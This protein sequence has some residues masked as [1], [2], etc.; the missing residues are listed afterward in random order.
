MIYNINKI[1]NEIDND[2][3]NIKPQLTTLTTITDDNIYD[4]YNKKT[5]EIKNKK[6]NE[7]KKTLNDYIIQ[8]QHK[9]ND[10]KTNN[11]KIIKD[12]EN[13]IYKLK[14]LKKILN[15][16]L[17]ERYN[18]YLKSS[19][20]IKKYDEYNKNYEIEMN[21]KRDVI[22]REHTNKINEELDKSFKKINI[23][24]RN[25]ELKIKELDKE[26]KNM[27]DSIENNKNLIEENNNLIKQNKDLNESIEKNISDIEKLNDLELKNEELLKKIDK[28]N[29]ILK[30][31]K[32]N[33]KLKKNISD[34]IKNKEKDIKIKE[35]YILDLKEEEK[36]LNKKINN[37]NILNNSLNEKLNNLNDLI[38]TK[39]TEYNVI[40]EDIVIKNN[41]LLNIIDKINITSDD[42]N[43]ITKEYNL[44]KNESLNLKIIA[45]KNK[46][47][48]KK[49]VLNK[50]DNDNDDDIFNQPTIIKN[51]KTYNN[52]PIEKA[53]FENIANIKR[54]PKL[55]LKNITKK[56]EIEE[57]NN[58]KSK[59]E[60]EDEI[61]NDLNIKS[62]N[63]IFNNY[64]TD[65]ITDSATIDNREILDFLYEFNEDNDSVILDKYKKLA[66]NNEDIPVKL[67][68]KRIDI[69]RKSFNGFSFNKVNE[70]ML[71]KKTPTRY[72]NQQYIYGYL[73]EVLQQNKKDIDYEK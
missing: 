51:I 71:G 2:F 35:N 57:N 61:K 43:E 17:D 63:E 72:Y 62:N 30:E 65:D 24:I 21:L 37:I 46:K 42:L 28:N 67:N 41:D 31:L 13:D 18:E 33:I 20:A 8:S 16:Y 45:Y 66:K 70:K 59:T 22:L 50:N 36:T 44:K 56:N 1:E 73:Y 12:Y 19:E 4:L 58:I 14:G 64:E 40:N 49:E 60:S 27:L 10:I 38:I 6:I 48:L 15:E 3:D 7:C 34:E 55:S 25:K 39:K 69:I 23:E 54:T 32:D 29:K 5:I 47:E 52:I 11:D 53:Q 26:Y 9:M 68:W